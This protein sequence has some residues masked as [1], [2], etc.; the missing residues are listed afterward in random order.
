MDTNGIGAC[1]STARRRAGAQISVPGGLVETDCDLD[2][3]A[4]RGRRQ[5]QE[6]A[7][8]ACAGRQSVKLERKT[9]VAGWGTVDFRR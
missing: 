8:L 3:I 1:D 7:S 2:G 6:G 5:R 4:G 9:L